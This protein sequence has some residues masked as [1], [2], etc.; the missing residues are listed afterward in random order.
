M[1]FAGK[2]PLTAAPAETGPK[3][4]RAAAFDTPDAENPKKIGPAPESEAE[5]TRYQRQRTVSEAGYSLHCL[6]CKVLF[7]C[8]V[9]RKLQCAVHFLLKVAMW[10]T[11]CIT[12]QINWM[13]MTAFAFYVV[14]LGFYLW[15][16]ITKTL[17][18]GAYKWYGI[19]VLIVECMGASTVILYGTNLLFNPVNEIILQENPDGVG[20]G[21]LKVQY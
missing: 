18:I 4:Y 3:Q 11:V 20:P 14:A 19:I 13:G 10:L 2:E 9:S 12:L 15:I 16:R 6:L 7:C 5:F 1:Y 8:R 21:I 17:D